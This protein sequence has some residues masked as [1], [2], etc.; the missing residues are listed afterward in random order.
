MQDNTHPLA[1]AVRNLFVVLDMEGSSNV[2]LLR[3]PSTLMRFLFD[4]ALSLEF[5]SI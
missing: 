3:I 1:E 2:V 5:S 4:S